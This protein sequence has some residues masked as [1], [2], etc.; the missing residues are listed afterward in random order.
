MLTSLR[1]QPLFYLIDS[2]SVASSGV[3]R[4]MKM[5]NF[6]TEEKTSG[7]TLVRGLNTFTQIHLIFRKNVIF[8]ITYHS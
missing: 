3:F 5:R 4:I 6:E 2:A 7:L 1:A 8:S